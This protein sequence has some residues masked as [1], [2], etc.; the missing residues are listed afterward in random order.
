MQASAGKDVSLEELLN[1]L[2][3]CIRSVE[4]IVSHMRF[5]AVDPTDRYALALLLVITDYARGVAS[6]GVAETFAGIPGQTRSALDA[7]VDIANLCDYPDYWKHL[8]AADAG[9]WSKVL[10][11]AS[12]GGN[13]FLQAITAS[14]YLRDGRSYYARKLKTLASSGIEK[15]NIDERFEK[16]G[17]KNEY[18][19]AY[20][21]M[22]AEAHNNVSSLVSRYFD[23]TEDEIRLRQPGEDN[24]K[25]AHYELPCTLMMSEIL[26]RST[27]KV[28]KHCGHG[29]A[30]LSEAYE[31]F[32]AIAAIVSGSEVR[33]EVAAA[34][35][36]EHATIKEQTRRIRRHRAVRS[37]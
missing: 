3:F 17:L 5:D 24:Q 28:L 21:L 9:S 25:T 14:E 8:E 20:G 16:A 22:S 13:P 18:E 6:A 36:E 23:I 29:V 15:L 26:L 31:R 10:Q 12:R 33:Q 37:A 7:Y 4:S 30:K 11:A 35:P 34:A 32:H 2:H 27:E 19:A 1:L